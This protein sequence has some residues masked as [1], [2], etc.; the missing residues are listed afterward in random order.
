MTGPQQP[1]GNEVIFE[2]VRL[3]PYMKVTAIDPVSMVEVSVQGPANA[4]DADLKKL[5]FNKLKLAV[6]KR[7]KPS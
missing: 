1:T 6:E 3:G 4:R 5:A 7:K 2:T